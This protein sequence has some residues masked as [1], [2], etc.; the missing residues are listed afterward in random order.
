MP[1]ALGRARPSWTRASLSNSQGRTVT[2]TSDPSRLW[3]FT[4]IC[5]FSWWDPSHNLHHLLMIFAEK[6]LFYELCERVNEFSSVFI[7]KCELTLVSIFVWWRGWSTFKFWLLK[8]SKFD[9]FN[10]TNRSTV[11]FWRTINE[12]IQ[13]FCHEKRHAFHQNSTYLIK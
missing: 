2:P 7:F 10:L 12:K 11:N 1:H 13:Y 5:A 4:H 3:S 9:Q 8:L 6:A